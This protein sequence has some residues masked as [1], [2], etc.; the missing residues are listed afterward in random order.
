MAL[1]VTEKRE[2]WMKEL[3]SSVAGITGQLD[4]RG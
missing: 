3:S 1:L 2:R 4:K